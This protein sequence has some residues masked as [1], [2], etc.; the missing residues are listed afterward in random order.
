M[1]FFT[2]LQHLL[3]RATAWAVTVE[4]TLRK[5]LEGLTGLPS[6][7][8]DFVDQVHAD[9][10][11]TTTRELAEW[12]R[13]FG[14]TAGEDEDTRR[15]ALAAAWAAQGG[16]SPR[17]IQDT[18]QSAGFDLYVHEW[19]EPGSA[20]PVAR[21]PRDY[22]SQPLIGIYQASALP[23]QPQCSAL[24]DQPQC[25]RFL[26]NETGYLVNKNLTDVAPPP[27][28][29]D[30]TKWPYFLYV[31]GAV[32]PEVA[33]VLESRR[34]ELERLLL[35]YCPTQNWIVTLV[36]Y[37]ASVVDDDDDPVIEDGGGDVVAFA[38]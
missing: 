24:P 17:Y 5:F 16:Q 33:L 29:D 11:P 13:Q 30:S 32:F 8:R 12:E 27:V 4:K 6:D 19:W 1:L 3:P 7:I 38:E 35:K 21:D 36:E 34:A 14:L 22:T 23:D 31:G 18:L 28:P 15:M 37:S 25:N 2:Q 9:R 10:M 26:A 20:P